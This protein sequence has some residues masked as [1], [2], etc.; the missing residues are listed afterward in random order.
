M[1]DLSRGTD[2]GRLAAEAALTS[3]SVDASLC[4]V[5]R[6][7]VTSQPQHQRGYSC[8]KLRTCPGLELFDPLV[9]LRS[10]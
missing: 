1:C 5:L 8:I 4:I 9:A 10:S 7:R 2:P 3:H 6:Q